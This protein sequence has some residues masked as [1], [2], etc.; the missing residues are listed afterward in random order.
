MLGCT[1]LG[2]RLIPAAAARARWVQL[3]PGAVLCACGGL[4]LAGC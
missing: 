3:A 1:A 4:V 2:L